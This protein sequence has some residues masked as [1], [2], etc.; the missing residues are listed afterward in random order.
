M[1]KNDFLDSGPWA[2]D[3]CHGAGLSEIY[4]TFLIPSLLPLQQRVGWIF[5]N[6]EL[7]SH[8]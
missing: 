2:S 7:T 6:D 4:L 5:E 3:C 8:V 1:R